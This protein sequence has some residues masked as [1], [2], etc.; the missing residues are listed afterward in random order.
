MVQFLGFLVCQELGLSYR[1]KPGKD[2]NGLIIIIPTA[3]MLVSPAGTLILAPRRSIA[4]R[5]GITPGI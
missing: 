1:E 5:G 3:G 2:L 4:G